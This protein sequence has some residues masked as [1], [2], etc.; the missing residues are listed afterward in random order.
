MVVRIFILFCFV[1]AFFI[2]GMLIGVFQDSFSRARADQLT[3]Q[4]LF[5]RV[6]AI[7]AFSLIDVDRTGF[8]SQLEFRGFIEYL[9]AHHEAHFRVSG[10][11]LFSVLQARAASSPPGVTRLAPRKALRR[12]CPP[13][14]PA[15]L[16]P[17]HDRLTSI[18][19]PR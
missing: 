5:E 14:P 10:D 3:N 2:V 1:G 4:K 18:T 15:I 13:P 8:V 12:R 9:E 17:H 11:E 16:P 6:G 7:A 19:S